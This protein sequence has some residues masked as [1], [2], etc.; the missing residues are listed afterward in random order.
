MST[1][2]DRIRLKTYF[3]T[4]DRPTEGEFIE[5][6]DSIIVQNADHIWVDA[7]SDA[8]N[9][10]IGT[11]FPQKKLHVNGNTQLDGDTH[12]KGLITVGGDIYGDKSTQDDDKDLLI[13]RNGGEI[14]FFG[15][16][17][18]GRQGDLF[19]IGDKSDNGSGKIVFS[20]LLGPGAWR[21]NMAIDTHG[22][23][24]IGTENPQDALQIGTGLA[25]L[26]FGSAY[27][28]NTGWGGGYIGFNTARNNGSW[29][30]ETDLGNNGA[31]VIYSDVSGGL[32]FATLATDNPSVGGQT[33]SDQDLR[34]NIK[35]KIR[36]DGNVGIGTTNPESKLHI[37]HPNSDNTGLRLTGQSTWA[38]GQI[39]VADADGTAKWADGASAVTSLWQINGNHIHNGNSGNVGIG[40]T[41]PVEKLHVSGRVKFVNNS[42]ELNFIEQSHGNNASHAL[43]H[44]K[45][46]DITSEGSVRYE[47][48]WSNTYGAYMHTNGGA[49]GISYASMGTETGQLYIGSG[50]GKPICFAPANRKGADLAGWVDHDK[51]W[52]LRGKTA[53]GSPLSNWVGVIPPLS[54]Y[55]L[56]VFGNNTENKALQVRGNSNF[57][58]E[59]KLN[60]NFPFVIKQF[61]TGPRVNGF[62][63]VGGGVHED[64]Y[65][66][67][68]MPIIDY[69]AA[70]IVGFQ[71]SGGEIFRDIFTEIHNDVWRI[72]IKPATVYSG[73]EFK[74]DVLFVRKEIIERR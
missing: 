70:C 35:L 65:I 40:V 68:S 12:V 63:G 26:D 21:N 67:T 32:N 2:R 22:N 64:Q 7:D 36:N 53:I 19:L 6:I 11:E 39:L 59:I 48:M 20:Q 46:G 47:Q 10:G 60:N 23:V 14:Q 44:K 41:N 16:R 13:V 24:G 71:A 50:L 51:N 37:H 18:P 42:G 49:G 56:D 25:K 5:F 55:E 45:T 74:V 38:P 66:Y 34:N 9:V 28:E 8:K 33:R 31:A 30:T 69:P 15:K 72:K 3:E 62:P 73:A 61:T 27:G 54:G 52:F 4:G 57:N 58:G 43:E 17:Y 29:T 1:K